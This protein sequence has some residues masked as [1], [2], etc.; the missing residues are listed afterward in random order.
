ME[1]DD[2]IKTVNKLQDAFTTVGLSTPVDLP[3]IVV[4]G[5]QSSG[6]SSVLENI[7]KRDFLPRGSGIVTR[8]P[9]I[10]Q[11]INNRK[12]GKPLEE[13]TAENKASDAEPE[14]EWGEFLHKPNEKFF[15]FEKIRQEIVQDTEA[16]TGGNKGISP[17]P[18]NLRIYSPHVLTL[19]LVD[20]PGLTKV[21]VG[22]QPK[23]I[24]KQIREMIMKYIT[25]PNAIILA[26]TSANTDLANSDGLKL[27]RE[28]DPDGTRTIG[29]LTKIDLMDAGTDVVEILAGRIIPLRHGYIPVVNRGQ[30]DIDSR[31]S[32]ERA[33]DDEKRY[34]ESHPTYASKAQFCGTP[35][36]ARKLNS[37]L[38]AHIKHCL[39]EIKAKIGSTLASQQAELHQ[40][41]D[42][43]IS[44]Q[45]TILSV[46]TEFCNDYKDILDGNSP[47]L[48]SS[49]LSGG[50]R[51]SF[52]FHEIFYNAIS[53][54]DSFDQ[55]RDNDIRTLLYNTSGSSPAL[56]VPSSAFKILSKQQIKRLE[57]PSLKC[58]S[59]IHEELVRMLTEVLRKPVFKRFP[60]LRER[61]HA[62]VTGFF[63]RRVEATSRMVTS[64]VAAECAYINV[65][66]PDFISGHKAY[67]VVQEK[68]YGPKSAQSPVSG[69]GISAVDKAGKQM[70]KT[71]SASL[72]ENS[73]PVN[74]TN[75]LFSSFFDSKKNANSAVS[76]SGKK[77]AIAGQLD[78]MPNVLKASGQVSERELFDIEVIKLFLHSYFG[79]VKRTICDMVPKSVVLNMVN[80]TKEEL[81][82]TLLAELYK[83]NLVDEL[84]KESELVT[85]RRK[86]CRKM[87]QALSKADEIVANL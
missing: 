37:I 47:E 41:G 22:D 68:L 11:L 67:A 42:N 56:F 72:Y 51:I 61:F 69:A 73:T 83:P 1:M 84:L 12:S 74:N 81:Q 21:P 75:G 3:Q 23:D 35:F 59:M 38:L 40:L 8:R 4:I 82:A 34:F 70:E 32:I 9:L 13:E 87:I 50:A 46:I 30:R 53:C 28:V 29:V 63:N 14:E 64:I 25:K 33:L 54:M 16:K 7:V 86:E 66:H 58:V 36:L 77:S 71:P 17:M 48:S 76:S 78:V 6:K 5:S 45:N 55:L 18:I 20:L 15:D 43:D 52:V 39:P 19:T 24:E 65:C 49:E 31:K 57:D 60:V 79:I 27:A 2:L 62:V 26:V 10:L 80:Y 85:E 44:G